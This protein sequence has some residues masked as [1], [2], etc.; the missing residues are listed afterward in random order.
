MRI[1]VSQW[2]LVATERPDIG[3]GAVQ[4]GVEMRAGYGRSGIVIGAT[5]GRPQG[6]GGTEDEYHNVAA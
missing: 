3:E 4:Q 5:S 1:T 6:K 2:K